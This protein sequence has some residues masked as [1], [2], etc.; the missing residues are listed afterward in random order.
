MN[1]ND[2]ISMFNSKSSIL[3]SRDGPQVRCP[4]QTQ[5]KTLETGE[6]AERTIILVSRSGS[7]HTLGNEI[8]YSG[9]PCSPSRIHL[10]WTKWRRGSLVQA[11]PRRGIFQKPISN[12]VYWSTVSNQLRS[13]QDPGA[14]FHKLCVFYGNDRESK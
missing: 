2:S 7:V 6:I 9:N 8:G 3:V 1:F 10:N 11:D 12:A 13:C 14:S 4:E 5:T